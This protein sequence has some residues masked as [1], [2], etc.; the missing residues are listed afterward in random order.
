MKQIARSRSGGSGIGVAR[1]V[2]ASCATKKKT[3]AAFMTNQAAALE[4]SGEEEKVG[5]RCREREYCTVILYAE[6]VAGRH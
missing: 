6:S 4:M 2:S 3:T 1:A 5:E